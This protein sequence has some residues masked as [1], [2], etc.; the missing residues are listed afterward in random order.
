[1]QKPDGIARRNEEFFDSRAE[2]YDKRFWFTHKGLWKFV[3]LLQLGNNPYLLDL[4]CGTG[5]ALRY[6]ANRTKGQG[7]FY[8]VD[9]S[10]KMIEQAKPNLKATATCIF[11][12][13]E[14]K[15]PPFDDDFFDV[16]ISS[17]AIHHFSNPEKPLR[18]ANRVLKPKGQ[19]YILD[20]T[21]NNA[22]MRVVDRFTRK[23]EPAHV[24]YCSTKEFQALFERARLCYI[25]SKR[26]IPA[27]EV[28]IAEK[29]NLN[30]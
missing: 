3:F 9:N 15:S 28:H 8:C 18:E 7:E 11:T 10:S 22:F 23:I 30:A 20:A 27:V 25:A 12:S 14:L 24:K 4:G 1:M 26:I 6:A 29:A 21:A 5:W 16:V 2:T 17:S 19:L 13:Q